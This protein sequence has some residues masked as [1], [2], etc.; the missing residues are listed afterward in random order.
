MIRINVEYAPEVQEIAPKLTGKAL[1]RE[2]TAF[3]ADL[4]RFLHPK[5]IWTAVMK[6]GREIQFDND[7]EIDAFE[8]K[9]WKEIKEIYSEEVD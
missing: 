8:A 5:L 6:D 3:E 4:E 1:K 9:H 2:R 7:A